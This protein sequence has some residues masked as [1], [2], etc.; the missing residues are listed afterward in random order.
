MPWLRSDTG[1]VWLDLLA[2]QSGAYGPAPTERLVDVGRLAWWLEVEGL[3]PRAGL[4][5]QD[6][7]AARALRDALRAVALAV[8]HDRPVPS[9][10]V[11]VLNDQLAADRPLTWPLQAPATAG[12]ALG[13]VAREAVE[14]LSGARCAELH[15]CADAE[16]GLLF[17]DAGGR[18]RWCAAEVCGVRNRVRSH[19]ERARSRS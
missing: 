16:C 4:T 10:E 13:R 6:L 7:V 18:R 12:Q 17:L 8:V 2:T 11:V 5:D 19:R 15:Q 3:L 14:T 1:A 9:A